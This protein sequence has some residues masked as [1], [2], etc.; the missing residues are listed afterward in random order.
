VGGST[1]VT[2]DW[3]VVV[4]VVVVVVAVVGVVIAAAADDD[5]DCASGT[6]MDD[7]ILEDPSWMG[8]MPESLNGE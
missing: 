8:D 4:V 3:V 6:G 5:D 2:N 7:L 1:R